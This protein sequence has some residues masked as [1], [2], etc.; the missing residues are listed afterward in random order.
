MRARIKRPEKPF[1]ISAGRTAGALVL[2]VALVGGLTQC[3]IPTETT[4]SPAPLSTP[5]AAPTP[6]PVDDSMTITTAKLLEVVDGDTIKTSLGTVRL[7]GI[8]TPESGECGYDE[9][10]ALIDSKISVGD[11]VTLKLPKGQHD[12]D[13][14]DRLLRYVLDKRGVDLG[15]SQLQ[16]GNAVA[17]YD[18]TE[19]HPAHP[20]ETNY[21]AVQKATLTADGKVVTT[22]CAQAADEKAAAEREAAEQAAAEQAAAL[23][24]AEQAAAEQQAAAPAP[25]ESPWYMEY[26]SCAALKRNAAGH[27]TGPFNRDDPAQLDAYNW[28]QYGTG[29][30][31]DGDGDGLACE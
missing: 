6:A 27:P 11:T 28:F 26:P 24:A 5:T 14:H 25:A 30:R 31:G 17:R 3:A 7:I 8:D 29:H 22:A 10:T 21:H 4:Q 1:T 9:A 18:S 13:R 20:N 2:A 16:A 15:R 23:A 19:G 12:K